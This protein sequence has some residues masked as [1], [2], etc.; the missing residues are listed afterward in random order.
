MASF[1]RIDLIFWICEIWVEKKV[2]VCQREQKS[3]QIYFLF[4]SEWRAIFEFDG[5]GFGVHYAF[6][7]VV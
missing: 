5:Q 6:I 2:F 3:S 1:V 4:A 7:V